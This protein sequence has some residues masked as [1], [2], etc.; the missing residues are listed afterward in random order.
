MNKNLCD[1]VVAEY[2]NFAAFSKDLLANFML[3]FPCIFVAIHQHTFCFLLNLL[4]DYRE[5]ELLCFPV[6][7]F[8]IPQ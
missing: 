1:T 4:P 6:W 8:V 2:L 7:Y 5:L 3:F